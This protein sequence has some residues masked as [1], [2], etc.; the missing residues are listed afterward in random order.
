MRSIGNLF[1]AIG[2]LAASINALSG[3][4]D[5]VSGRLRQQ[6]AIDEAAPTILE[7]NAAG[8][9]NAVLDGGTNGTAKGRKRAGAV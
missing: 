1:S 4:V 5:T 6:L 9:E 7:H 2:N 3:L 8:S